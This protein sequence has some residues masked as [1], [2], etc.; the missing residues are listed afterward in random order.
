MAKPSA[1]RE[2]FVVR[3]GGTVT[4]EEAVEA[5]DADAAAQ[6]VLR[7]HAEWA[8]DGDRIFV[9]EREHVEVRHVSVAAPELVR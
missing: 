1:L 5:L 4:I 6:R 3:Y 8:R 9:V 2:F 7:D